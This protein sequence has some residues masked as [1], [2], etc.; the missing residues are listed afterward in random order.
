MKN[1]N[2]PYYQSLREDGIRRQIKRE[3]ARIAQ[4]NKIVQ[5]QEK[6][7]ELRNTQP[8]KQYQDKEYWEKSYSQYSDGDGRDEKWD[9]G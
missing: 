3:K 7:R 6:L 1:Y 8:V 2:T 4:E 5:L 9:N